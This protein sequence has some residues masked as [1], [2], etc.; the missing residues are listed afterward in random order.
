[1]LL[2]MGVS[3]QALALTASVGIPSG[4]CEKV[5]S[6]FRL[7]GNFSLGTPVSSTTYNWLVTSNSEAHAGGK[8]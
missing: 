6:D 4:A 5:A 1:M 3:S 7:G 2:L 8:S